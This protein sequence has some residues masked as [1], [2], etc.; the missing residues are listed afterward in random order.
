MDWMDFPDISEPNRVYFNINLEKLRWLIRIRWIFGFFILVFFIIHS[1]LLKKTYIDF[2]VFFGILFLSVLGNAVFILV[3]E[4]RIARFPHHLRL[5]PVLAS[6]Q[7]G[8][9]FFILSLFVLFSGGFESPARV[10]FILRVSARNARVSAS[11]S[12]LLPRHF[13]ENIFQ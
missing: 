6:V 9:D 13:Q 7:L 8:F 1:Y 12:G 5:L 3:L 2:F 4:K 11:I 10:L